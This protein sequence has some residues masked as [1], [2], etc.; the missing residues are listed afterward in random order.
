MVKLSNELSSVKLVQ[1]SIDFILVKKLTILINISQKV[2]FNSSK[3]VCKSNWLSLFK[4]YKINIFYTFTILYGNLFT[5]L[6]QT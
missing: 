6:G 3:L 2:L 5:I 4:I 1:Y